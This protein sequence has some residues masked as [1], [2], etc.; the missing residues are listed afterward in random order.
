VS[1][2]L[3]EMGRNIKKSAFTAVQELPG[4]TALNRVNNYINVLLVVSNL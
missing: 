1:I 2:A 3:E 4:K